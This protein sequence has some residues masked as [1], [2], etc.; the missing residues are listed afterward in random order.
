MSGLS[1]PKGEGF[2]ILLMPMD[3]M[4]FEY[5][6]DPTRRHCCLNCSHYFRFM[7]QYD[8]KQIAQVNGIKDPHKTGQKYCIYNKVF[9]FMSDSCGYFREFKT[10]L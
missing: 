7:K 2:F 3:E 6:Y 4:T 10:Y 1:L 5:H 8:A 9:V